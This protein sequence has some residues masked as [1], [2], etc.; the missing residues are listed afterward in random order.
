MIKIKSIKTGVIIFFLLFKYFTALKIRNFSTILIGPWKGEL[1][2]EL[3]YW[4]PFVSFFLKNKKIKKIIILTRKPMSR[5]YLQSL[6]NSENSKIDFININ[7][8]KSK[9]QFDNMEEKNT[10][11]KIRIKKKIKNNFFILHPE[12]FYNFIRLHSIGLIGISTIKRLLNLE[13]FK[14]VKKNKINKKKIF[15]IWLYKNDYLDKKQINLKKINH[16][17]KKNNTVNLI[18]SNESYQNH[19]DYSHREIQFNNKKIN[20]KYVKYSKKN[21]SKNLNKIFKIIENSN[22]FCSTWGG[23]SYLGYYLGTNILFLYNKKPKIHYK[24]RFIENSISKKIDYF[25]FRHLKV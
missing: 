18:Y 15:T 13:I 10:L 21:F 6:K 17:L 11:R 1:G 23:S 16:I 19:T 24:H 14:E 22:Y 12:Y 2:Y 20:I 4:I 3:L 5:F 7:D 9:K 8:Y 25:S